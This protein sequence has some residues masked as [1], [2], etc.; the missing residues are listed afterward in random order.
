V[1]LRICRDAVKLLKEYSDEAMPNEA[2]AILVGRVN[3]LYGQVD[4]IYLVPNEDRSPLSF[5]VSPEILA[6][7][8]REL[9][10]RDIIGIFHSHPFWKAYPSSADIEHM[11]GYRFW[12]IL[13]TDGIRCFTLL[14]GNVIEVNIKVEDRSCDLVRVKK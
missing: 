4:V 6:L 10:E 5:S 14:K 9:G 2:V 3:D 8:T 13:G 12:L 7:I 1:D 11:W